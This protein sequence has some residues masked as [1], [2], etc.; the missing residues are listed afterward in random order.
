MYIYDIQIYKCIEITQNT[1]YPEIFNGKIVWG[2]YPR[3]PYAL[4]IQKI[5]SSEVFGS[6]LAVLAVLCFL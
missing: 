6:E 1:Q 3:N 5:W 4:R 2:Q